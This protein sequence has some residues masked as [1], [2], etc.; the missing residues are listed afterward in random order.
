RDMKYFRAQM[1]QMLQ[2]LLPDLPPET[3]ANVA[4]PYM[5]VDAYTVEA[6]GTGEMIPEERLTCNLTALMST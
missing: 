4:R 6:E 2:G 1:L 5:T 3:V